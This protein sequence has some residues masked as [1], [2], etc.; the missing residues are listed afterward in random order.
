MYFYINKRLDIDSKEVDY[1]DNDC[2]SMRVALREEDREER[3]KAVQIYNIY[4][5]LPLTLKTKK[6]LSIISKIVEVLKRVE[7][8]ILLENFNLYYLTQNN[9]DRSIYYLAVDILLD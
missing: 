6:Y 4:N 2:Y 5:L 1:L 7:K 8:Y 3:K 9:L